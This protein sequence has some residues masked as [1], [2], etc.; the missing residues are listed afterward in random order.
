MARASEAA[1][2]IVATAMM[3]RVASARAG[4]DRCDDRGDVVGWVIMIPLSIALFLSAV[5][6]AMWHQ[7]RNM[8]Q[9]AAQSG[10]T[11]GAALTA[12][13]NAGKSAAQAYISTEAGSSVTS[14]SATEQQ[15][16]TTVTVTCHAKAF[17]LLPLP[18]LTTADQSATA[19]RERFTTPGT[20]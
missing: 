2:R 1:R 7:A 15:T 10:A 5:Q 18:G 20:P 17:T 4:S 13:L 14:A 11:A 19:T 3:R 6:V 9:G 16:A 12:G 8:C